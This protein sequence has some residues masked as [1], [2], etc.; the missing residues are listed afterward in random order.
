MT[1]YATRLVRN[2]CSLQSIEEEDEECLNY[3][4]I[5][6]QIADKCV[7]KNRQCTEK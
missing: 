5:L 1:A 3:L 7:L 2:K 4:C 6:P